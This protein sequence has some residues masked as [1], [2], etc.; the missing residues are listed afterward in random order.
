M[1]RGPSSRHGGS[2][3]GKTGPHLGPQERSRHGI[4]LETHERSRHGIALETHE[5]SRHGIALETHERSRHGVARDQV[6]DKVKLYSYEEISVY[7]FG[8]K[9]GFVVEVGRV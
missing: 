2:H 4:A 9:F 3:R 5:R 6:A 7:C 8:R 1:S